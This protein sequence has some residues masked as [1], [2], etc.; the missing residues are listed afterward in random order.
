MEF[1]VIDKYQGNML[2][3]DDE[4]SI[5]PRVT[6]IINSFPNKSFIGKQYNISKQGMVH[7][8]KGAWIG[9]GTIIHPGISIGK[10][11]IIGSGTVVTKDVPDYSIV[12]GVPGKIVG[13]VRETFGKNK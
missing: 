10:G 7:I 2:E 9:T 8:E 4:V 6:I 11:T 13:D 1:L 3:I 5:A 12:I